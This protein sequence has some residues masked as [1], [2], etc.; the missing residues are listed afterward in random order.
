MSKHFLIHSNEILFHRL[1]SSKIFIALSNVERQLAYDVIRKWTY[2]HEYHVWCVHIKDIVQGVCRIDFWSV[3]FQWHCEVIK[4]ESCKNK[5]T[6]IPHQY[7]SSYNHLILNVVIIGSLQKKE[8]SLWY[9]Y[10]KTN[11]TVLRVI[12]ACA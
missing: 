3:S 12:T 4:K 8:G 1:C 5:G 9:T 11:W 10:N 6:R 2:M 7:I